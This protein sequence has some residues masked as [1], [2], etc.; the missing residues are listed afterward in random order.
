MCSVFDIKT[1]SLLK[2]LNLG[3]FKIPSGEI[4][5]YPL[6]IELGK[7]NKKIILSTGMSTLKEIQNALKLLIKSGTSKKLP[8]FIAI[9]P[10]QQK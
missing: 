7:M 9:V 1:L 4:N 10:I 5:N 6:L 8:C 2:K 3:C